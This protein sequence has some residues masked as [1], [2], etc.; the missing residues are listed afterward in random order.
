M[1]RPN[2]PSVPRDRTS[3]L[4]SNEEYGIG[5]AP[6]RQVDQTIDGKKLII[7]QS[8]EHL[9]LS[10]DND[11]LSTGDLKNSPGVSQQS[12][13]R[14]FKLSGLSLQKSG[15]YGKTK[16]LGAT[17]VGAGLGAAAMAAAAAGAK[18]GAAIGAIAGFAI[19]IPYVGNLA[20]AGLG[21]VVGG[22]VGLGIGIYAHRKATKTKRYLQQTQASLEKKGF[23][24]DRRGLQ[25]LETVEH[26]DWKTLLKID[27]KMVP[28]K[29]ARREIREQLM[30]SVA[31]DGLDAAKE[32]KPKLEALFKQTSRVKSGTTRRLILQVAAATQREEGGDAGKN[33]THL[34]T[35]LSFKAEATGKKSESAK[36]LQGQLENVVKRIETGRSPSEAGQHDNVLAGALD[37]A[38]GLNPNTA[39]QGWQDSVA[40]GSNLSATQPEVTKAAELLQEYKE[41]AQDG[42][43]VQCKRVL[44]DLAFH[45]KGW[46]GRV[47]DLPAEASRLLLD[48]ENELQKTYSD[49]RVGMDDV[50]KIAMPESELGKYGPHGKV[51]MD[52]LGQHIKK[53]GDKYMTLG[54]NWSGGLS[55]DYNNTD[56]LADWAKVNK[57]DDVPGLIYRTAKERAKFLVEV[58]DGKMYQNDKLMNGD[59][60]LFVMD[61]QGKIYA[62]DK[63]EGVHHSSLLA[64]NPVAAAGMME[65]KNGQ[66]TFLRN[67]SGHYTPTREYTE[68]FRDE[69]KSRGVNF[70]NVKGNLGHYSEEKRKLLRD[71]G[72]N[73]DNPISISPRIYPD[74]GIVHQGF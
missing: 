32:L 33:I 71:S 6:N 74:L 34:L 1:L 19:P 15:G 5:Q 38:T 8:N 16:A 55:K 17:A 72:T 57:G 30:A 10:N 11:S 20:G 50:K 53:D 28:D 9:N 47:D 51:R 46:A 31:M 22:L 2:D 64:G 73:P 49:V 65:V 70:D 54:M 59:G 44:S 41:R 66:L 45:L 23:K 43:D 42:D 39:V 52:Y 29:G 12:K 3:S 37:A 48:T 61:G 25:R 35:K 13:A 56:M 60:Y 14:R 68:Q 7:K 4:A 69:I 26:K 36:S 27:S 58:R 24:T 67:Y 62:A 63:S 18:T 40:A 21:A